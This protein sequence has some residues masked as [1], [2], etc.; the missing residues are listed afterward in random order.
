MIIS[1]IGKNFAIEI[2]FK[3]ESG[4]DFC[5]DMFGILSKYARQR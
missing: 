5:S 4:D 3:N 1:S 2:D